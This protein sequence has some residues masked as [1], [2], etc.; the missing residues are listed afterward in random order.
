MSK[1]TK[2]PQEKLDAVTEFLNKEIDWR[3]EILDNPDPN[4]YQMELS[5]WALEHGVYSKVLEELS[6]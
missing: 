4:M 3:K 2:T 1:T 5:V 6:K